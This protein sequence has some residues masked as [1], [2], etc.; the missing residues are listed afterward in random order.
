MFAT[1][2]VPTGNQCCFSDCKDGSLDCMYRNMSVF[3]CFNVLGFCL[4]TLSDVFL[5][6]FANITWFG[7]LPLRRMTRNCP[8]AVAAILAESGVKFGL[9]GVDGVDDWSWFGVFT[10][11][12]LPV[13][14]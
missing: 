14:V 12:A 10:C 3:R 4:D 1:Y 5:E 13:M 6:E 9:V 7:A 2:V 8:G 11:I